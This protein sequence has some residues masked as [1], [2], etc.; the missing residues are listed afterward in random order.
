MSE[1]LRVPNAV[2]VNGTVS[3]LVLEDPRKH[4]S[5]NTLRQ[6]SAIHAE[7]Q[8]THHLYC[9]IHGLKI[10]DLTDFCFPFL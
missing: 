9:A 8:D 7:I 10:T 5:L 1:K 6:L 3:R 2:H 4:N